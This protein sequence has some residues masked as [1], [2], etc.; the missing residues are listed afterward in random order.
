MVDNEQNE[1]EGEF[2][3]GETFPYETPEF[4]TE[5]ASKKP[6]KSRLWSVTKLLLK[7]AVTC[8][9]LYYVF[10]KININDVKALVSQANPWWALSAVVCFFI[11]TIV[12][13][14]RLL[15]FFKSID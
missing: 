9:L 12:S 7:I 15:S 13:A 11:S 2:G 1:L 3:P 6:F 4:I 14:S 10:S 5:P 8:A